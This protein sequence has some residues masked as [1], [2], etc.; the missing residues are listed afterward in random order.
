[1]LSLMRGF[2]PPQRPKRRP[3]KAADLQ[4]NLF[5]EL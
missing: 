5:G 1:M 4:E 3:E 2:A